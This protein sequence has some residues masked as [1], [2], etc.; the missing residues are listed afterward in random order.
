[1]AAKL[2][3]TALAQA[4][5]LIKEGKV[6]RDIRDDWSEHAPSTDQEN[7]FIDKHGF[8]DFAA[9]HLGRDDEKSEGT[10]GSVSFPT[11]T[12]ARCTGARSSRWR[13]GPPST[14]TTTSAMRR[15]SC[16]N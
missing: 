1:M 3:R 7:S 14:A 11:G 16:W 8:K 9:W 2:N 4:R 15:G 10:K 12:S 6:E 5:Q 13:E